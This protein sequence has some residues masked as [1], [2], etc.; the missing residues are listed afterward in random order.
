MRKVEEYRKHAEECR[1]MARRSRPPD[2]RRMLLNMAETW[3]GLA[4]ARMNQVAQRQ[5]MKNIAVGPGGDDRM[6]GASIPI[7]CSNAG[8]DELG[9]SFRG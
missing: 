3:D 9:E 4:V 6:A 1:A 2:E 7:D 5:R 8:N